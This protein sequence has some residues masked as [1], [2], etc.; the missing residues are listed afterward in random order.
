[1]PLLGQRRIRQLMKNPTTTKSDR[2]RLYAST[3]V[4]QWVAAGFIFWRAHAHGVSSAQMGI[5][6]SKPI[7]ATIVAIVLTALILANQVFALRKLGEHPQEVRGVMP[8]L[9]M[10][11]FPQDS[12]ERVAFSGVVVTVALCEEFIFR[13]FVQRI[14]QGWSHG[15]VLV[16][17]LGSSALFAWAH[18]YQ[19]RRGLI[20]TFVAGLLF[21][22]IRAWTLSLFPSALAH[23]GAD[24]VV[25]FM[26]PSRFMA[27]FAS[28]EE[29]ESDRQV[30]SLVKPRS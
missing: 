15:S 28:L 11:I 25:G 22:T 7:L 8:Q 3:A 4:F 26:A 12:V 29:N 24:L 23:F 20:T 14:F 13:G 16:A 1:V 5:S 21:S 17:V 18:L 19:G 30:A 6:I 9:A 2:F 10:R 27:A